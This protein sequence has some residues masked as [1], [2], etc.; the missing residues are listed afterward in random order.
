MEALEFIAKAE[1]GKII[2]NVPERLEGKEVKVQV[3]EYN[4]LNHPGEWQKLSGA[5][6]VKILKRFAGTAKYPDVEINKY[7]VYEQ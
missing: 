3:I 6:R 4:V 1:A 2:I 5:E 7:D